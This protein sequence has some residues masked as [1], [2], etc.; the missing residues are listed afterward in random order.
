MHPGVEPIRVAQARKITPGS[1]EGLL[2]RVAGDLA[3]AG[4]EAGGRVQSR[5]GSSGEHG[6]GFAIASL[7]SFH[8]RPLVHGP[9]L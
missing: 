7:G 8:E 1:D 4:D 9:S 3:I 2:H 6:E 5:C